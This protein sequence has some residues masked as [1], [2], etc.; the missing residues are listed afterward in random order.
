MKT[1]YLDCLNFQKWNCEKTTY[2]KTSSV[3]TNAKT[4]VIT[5]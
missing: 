1:Y 5:S 3:I 2:E 4:T